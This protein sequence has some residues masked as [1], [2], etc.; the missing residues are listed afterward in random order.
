MKSIIIIILG[1]FLLIKGADILVSGA[2]GIAKKF[3]ISDIIVGLTIVSIGTS[4]PELM[5]SIKSAVSGYSDISIGNVLGSCIC[6]I[7]L[8]LGVS[9]LFQSIHIDKESKN[10]VL[11]LTL[12]A[13]ILIFVFGNFNMQ[14]TR[15]E[16]L[17]LIGVFSIFLMYI[18]LNM[19][20]SNNNDT[21]E[22]YKG[23]L[24][25][26]IIFIIIGIIGLKYGGDFVVNESSN[27]ARS[28]NI[29]ESIIGLTIVSIGTS[30][31]ELVTSIV[32]GKNGK[33]SIAFGNIIGSNIF[34][35]LLVLGLSSII[36]PINYSKDFNFTLIL[37]FL[38][39]SLILLFDKIGE[40]KKIDKI[41]GIAMLLI[42]TQYMLALF[43]LQ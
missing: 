23:N 21:Q 32:A 13:M 5:I 20:K 2:S 37:L 3:H 36:S 19:L 26:N 9:C 39:T 11:P 1:F 22:E 17:L 33:E 12:F 41:K 10:I 16:G 42:Y 18:I 34:N 43:A 7:L 4:L 6:N 31:P 40:K 38:I 24:F 27:I 35:L 30:L 14:I 15:F 8:I 29:S 25:K 28:F